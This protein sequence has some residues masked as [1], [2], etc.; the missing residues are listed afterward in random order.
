MLY[1]IKTKTYLKSLIRNPQ[2]FSRLA[3]SHLLL[4]Q[5]HTLVVSCKEKVELVQESS[6]VFQYF[7]SETELDEF[8]GQ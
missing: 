2:G 1:K 5:L 8:K 6:S 4:K 7:G 3:C